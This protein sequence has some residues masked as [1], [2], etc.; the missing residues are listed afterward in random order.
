MAEGLLQVNDLSKHFLLG[1]ER[2][3][4][5][6]RRVVRA[7]DGVSLSVQEGETLGLVGESGSGKS[8]TARLILRLLEPT[9]G[10]VRFE[11]Q[12]TF[13]LDP[14]AMW[15]LRQK[16]QIVF[17]DPYGSLNPRKRVGEIIG[18]PLEIYGIGTR[19]ERKR[20]VSELLEVV[21]LRASDEARY[22]HQFSGGQR[23]RIGI[24][25]A[26][27]LRPKLIVADEPVSALDVSVQ[28]QVLNLLNELK[29]RFRLTYIFI[30]HDLNVVLHMSDRVAVMYLGKIVEIGTRD[31]IHRAPKHPY[32]QALLS[33][34]PVADPRVKRDRILLAGEVGSPLNP[35]SG[36][37]F[38]PRCPYAF[39]VCP[40]IEPELQDLGAGQLVACHL[41]G[42]GP[43]PGGS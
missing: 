24:A 37:R 40:R 11:G 17:Q 4:G 21:G 20:R 28:G 6:R 8:T 9:G 13:Q 29:R 16:L 22:P 31:Q 25:A 26:L 43:R 7:V 14:K 19:D 33:A 42:P 5:G 15:R 34:I 30:A 38:H 35:P 39:D 23:Q 3:F 2:L 10:T 27:A 1:R 12:E 41:Y 18:E 36:C 32:T